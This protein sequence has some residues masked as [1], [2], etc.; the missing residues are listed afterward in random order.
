MN[1]Q[2]QGIVLRAF[3]CIGRDKKSEPHYGGLL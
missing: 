3:V 2:A 1:G